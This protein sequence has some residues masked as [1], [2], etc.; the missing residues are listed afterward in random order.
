MVIQKVLTTSLFFVTYI[1]IF[2]AAYFIIFMCYFYAVLESILNQYF[3]I[4]ISN[5]FF[6]VR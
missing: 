3:C 4:C 1:L 6:L 2:Y 5:V